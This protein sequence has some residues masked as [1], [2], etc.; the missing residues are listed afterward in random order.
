VELTLDESAVFAY[1]CQIFNGLN[2]GVLK[3]IINKST[4]D[5]VIVANQLI[6]KGLLVK[7]SDNSFSLE[8]TIKQRLQTKAHDEAHDNLNETEVKII[9]A[10]MQALSTSDLLEKLGYKIRTGNF[11]NALANL[12]NLEI[13]EMTIPESPRSKNQ[14]YIL[15]KKSLKLLKH[16]ADR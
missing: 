2:I 5:C 3:S 8:S 16:W 13:I 7:N 1:A 11:K 4:S 10:C 15:S 9:Q 14:K 6:D 12:L